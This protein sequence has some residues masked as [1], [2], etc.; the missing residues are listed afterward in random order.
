MEQ[1]IYL[2]DKCKKPL[3]EKKYK[4]GLCFDFVVGK[5]RIKWS[6]EV[7]WSCFDK[8]EKAL[9]KF[10]QNIKFKRLKKPNFR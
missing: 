10:Q 4:A 8:F 5:E 1:I 6:G 3:N 9:I 7:C 2:C